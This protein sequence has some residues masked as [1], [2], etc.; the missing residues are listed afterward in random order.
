MKTY[1]CPKNSQHDG[2]KAVSVARPAAQDSQIIC[3]ECGEFID[4]ASP[5]DLVQLHADTVH[6]INQ[7]KHTTAALCPLMS[8]MVTVPPRSDMY[9]SR[10]RFESMA[11]VESDCRWWVVD[12]DGDADCAVVMIARIKK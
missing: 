1:T 3:A 7:S 8:G 5:K 6:E 10:L 2:V 4:W 11:C 12:S 9:P